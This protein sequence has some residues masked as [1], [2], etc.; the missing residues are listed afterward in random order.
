MLQTSAQIVSNPGPTIHT[1]KHSP[2]L[3]P[4]IWTCDLCHKLIN[5]QQT[6]IRCNHAHNTHWVH[7]KFTQ[8]KQQQY[9]PYW[10]CT[11]HT[12]TTRNN[13]AK[14]I[15]HNSPSPNKQ[16]STKAQKHTQGHKHTQPLV[17]IHIGKPKH[18][19]VVNTY[20][21]LRDRT[22]QHYNTVVVADPP[23]LRVAVEG[24]DN[25]LS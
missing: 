6:S 8:I 1:N 10:R 12:P 19:T 22:L 15:Q 24:S 9:K 18:I 13:N 3:T 20:F 5:K 2:A 21:P 23:L 14:H 11:I 25:P 4:V 7:L 17:I 16:H